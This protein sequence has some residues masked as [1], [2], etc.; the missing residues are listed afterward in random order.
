QRLALAFQHH[1]GLQPVDANDVE[2]LGERLALALVGDEPHRSVI[3]LAH[4]EGARELGRAH[5]PI[6]AAIRSS[7][8]V[9][10]SGTG[11]AR[12]AAATRVVFGSSLSFVLREGISATAVSPCGSASR[13]APTRPPS[14]PISLP[15]CLPTTRSRSPLWRSWPSMSS[16]KISASRTE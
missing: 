9:A 7:D 12:A 3:E 16:M 8:E 14:V 1:F 11:L 6:R 5:R 10:A 2:A 4:V 13:S 15:T